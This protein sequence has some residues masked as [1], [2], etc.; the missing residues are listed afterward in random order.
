MHL[1]DFSEFQDS[2]PSDISE[3][4]AHIREIKGMDIIRKSRYK[5]EFTK[6]EEMTRLN[7]IKYSNE[8]EGIRTSDERLADIVL[9][10]ETPLTHGENEIAGYRDALSLIHDNPSAFD[11]DERTILEL[12]RLMMNHTIRGGGRYKTRDNA[13]VSEYD[14]RKEIVFLP[15]SAKETPDCMNQLCLAYMEARDD[16]MEPLL[17]IPCVILDFL[18]IHPFS[19]GNGRVSRLLTSLMLYNNGFE[20]CRYVSMDEHIAMTKNDYYSSLAQSSKGWMENNWT[21][22]PFVRYFLRTLLECYMDLDTR[23]AMTADRPLKKGKRIESML[24]GSLTPISKKQ[25]CVALSDVSPRT[26]ESVLSRLQSEGKIEKIGSF[27]DARYR[28]IEDRAAGDIYIDG[29]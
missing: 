26:V 19:D 13:I 20:I 12:H 16:G 3:L 18:S 15:V 7:S 28:W 29:P 1:F 9:R 6:I 24:R 2:I 8:I 21:Y 5:R 23:F 27:K 25:I 10:N 17:L 11:L 4:I 22:V 14:G